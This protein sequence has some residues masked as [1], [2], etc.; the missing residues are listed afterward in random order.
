MIYKFTFSN[1]SIVV[2]FR[3]LEKDK[4]AI[5][6]EAKTDSRPDHLEFFLFV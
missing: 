4:N 2:R 6:F 1:L 3:A 5:S